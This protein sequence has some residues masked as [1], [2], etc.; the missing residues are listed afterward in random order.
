[1]SVPPNPRPTGHLVRPGQGRK[2]APSA[3]PNAP[4]MTLI[5]DPYREKRKTLKTGPS[6]DGPNGF[7]HVRPALF[8]LP[9]KQT[10]SYQRENPGWGEINQELGGTVTLLY[11]RQT[12]R[13]PLYPTGNSA[14]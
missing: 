11:V 12:T 2:G 8:L 6:P 13:D 3:G 7:L 4:S 14:Q 1:M 9:L 10:Y 5:G